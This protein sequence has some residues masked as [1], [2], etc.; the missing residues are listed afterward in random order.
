VNAFSWFACSRVLGEV[1]RCANAIEGKNRIVGECSYLHRRA[2]PN[3]GWICEV[4][5]TGATKRGRCSVDAVL[6][7]ARNSPG[8]E[9]ELSLGGYP[10]QR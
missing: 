4:S 2:F 8:K 7:F 1:D 6:V 10:Q 5:A 9:E 3:F